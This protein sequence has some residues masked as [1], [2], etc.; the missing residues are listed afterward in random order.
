MRPNAVRRLIASTM[1]V[2]LLTAGCASNG[3]PD[4]SGTGPDAGDSTPVTVDGPE[5][6]FRYA[7]IA[8][9][10]T[11]DP[12]PETRA[13]GVGWFQFVYDGLL[14]TDADGELQPSLATAWQVD[15]DRVE[16]TL[17]SDVSFHDG[18]PFDAEAVRFNIEKGQAAP[19]V[20]G[21]VLSIID[22]VEAVDS[23]QVVLHLAD[24]A[25]ALLD[26]L[27][28]IPGLMVSPGVSQEELEAGVPAGTGPYIIDHAASSPESIW[29]FNAN[30]DYWAPERV[31]FERIE[32]PLMPDP[33]SRLNALL[34]GQV[35]A[36]PVAPAHV[37]QLEGA[38]LSHAEAP[39]NVVVFQFL[40]LEGTQVPELADV[41]VRRA[42]AHAIDRNAFIS[43]VMGGVGDPL[44][45]LFGPGLLGHVDGYTGAS[46]DPDRARDLLA[47]AGASDLEFA[48]PADGRVFVP[49]ATA[50]QGMLADVGVTMRIENAADGAEMTRLIA[51]AEYPATYTFIPDRHPQSAYDKHLL[52]GAVYNP[53]SAM[54]DG[55]EAAH[56]DALGAFPD[57]QG[58]QAAY[59]AM[60]QSV[61]DE[62]W[63]IPIAQQRDIVA[64]NP[65]V[66][67]GVSAWTGVPLW[68]YLPSVAHTGS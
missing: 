66:V 68:P 67:S 23:H 47:Q 12:H 42:I 46:F 37:A 50:I 6:T 28:L 27:A 3:T 43:T 10:R 32:A 45:Q 64:W 5:G 21:S 31:V 16:L 14:R 54:L 49:G 26:Q 48:V 2:G 11:W 36:A 40:D 55:V 41:N 35:D 25:P 7:A 38:G 8:S 59:A 44:H 60:Y 15:D 58:L 22:R 61:Y 30:A 13:F 20:T 52:P 24:A 19:G 18:T 29:I 63:I 57:P 65:D 39:T 4:V 17:R 62:A 1:V 56:A 34:A 33:S 53:F 51:A 9:P